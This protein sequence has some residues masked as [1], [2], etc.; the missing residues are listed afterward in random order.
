MLCDNIY[1]YV[2]LGTD[3]QKP[4]CSLPRAIPP[5]TPV[6]SWRSGQCM[7]SIF[8]QSNTKTYFPFSWKGS[9]LRDCAEGYLT[10][11]SVVL[12]QS[13]ITPLRTK[14]IF[15]PQIRYQFPK[16]PSTLLREQGSF[17]ICPLL[18]AGALRRYLP[19]EAQ[20]GHPAPELAGRGQ[21]QQAGCLR[22]GCGDRAVGQVKEGPGRGGQAPRSSPGL[23]G[24][25]C[26]AGK[27]FHTH[28]V[29]EHICFC[30]L[31]DFCNVLRPRGH[32]HFLPHL[33]LMQK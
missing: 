27:H 18:F 11:L 29:Q 13:S 2:F 20:S 28:S 24:Q 21:E 8:F 22:W 7:G 31:S 4:V 19:R 17:C 3:K 14:S 32:S 26:P 6:Q 25:P 5:V 30:R 10:S 15:F 12:R 1:M 33:D 23:W 16:Y 9:V